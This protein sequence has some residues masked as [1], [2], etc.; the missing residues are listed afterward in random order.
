MTYEDWIKPIYDYRTSTN[1]N[2]GET[3]KDYTKPQRTR[4]KLL[5]KGKGKNIR[6]DTNIFGPGNKKL[7]PFRCIGVHG[8]CHPV[9]H[10]DGIYWGTHGNTNYGASVRLRLTEMNFSPCVIERSVSRRRMLRSNT[11]TVEQDILESDSDV[12]ESEDSMS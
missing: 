2:T 8:S 6:C 4:I 1:Q 5:T 7:S 3:Y 12:L 11:I 10:W 9:V